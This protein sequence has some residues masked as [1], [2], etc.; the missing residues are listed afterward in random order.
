MASKLKYLS[1][2]LF[3]FLALGSW[4]VNAQNQRQQELE[5]RKRELQKEIK[6]ILLQH[7]LTQELLLKIPLSAS[8][9]VLHY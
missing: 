2:I 3:I 1:F 8:T 5:G 9:K 7:K 4:G 6:L